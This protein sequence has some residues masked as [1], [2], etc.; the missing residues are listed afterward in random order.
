MSF[1]RIRLH[2][3][4][5]TGGAVLRKYKRLLAAADRSLHGW[6]AEAEYLAF[7]QAYQDDPAAAVA[8]AEAEEHSAA[9]AEAEAKA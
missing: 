9:E 2:Q 1:D 4:H 7:Q 8:A 6:P 5:A 3:L